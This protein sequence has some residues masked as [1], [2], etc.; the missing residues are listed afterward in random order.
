MDNVMAMEQNTPAPSWRWGLTAC[1]LFLMLLLQIGYFEFER[2][3][4]HPLLR[5]SL[6]SLCNTGLCTL[7]PTHAPDQVRVIE[8]AIRSHPGHQNA[9]LVSV[10]LENT[11]TSNIIYP[12]MVL[13]FSNNEGKIIAQRRFLPHEYLH[14]SI[15][16]KDGMP[17]K[18]AVLAQ[19]EIIDP[20]KQAFNYEF[21][22]F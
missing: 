4:H 16:I 5:G 6:A 19:L 1:T 17:A 13:S 2:L 20:G 7:P 14:A 8:R 15:N 10:T 3:S 22:F 18:Q 9:L 21:S 12:E 11:S